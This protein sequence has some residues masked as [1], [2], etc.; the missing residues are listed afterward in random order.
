MTKCVL[1]LQNS[2]TVTNPTNSYS[3]IIRNKQEKRHWKDD[4][5]GFTEGKADYFN[6]ENT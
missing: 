4:N 2:P 1:F 6:F 5:R 3:I